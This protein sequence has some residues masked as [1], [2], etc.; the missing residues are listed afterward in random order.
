MDKLKM[1]GVFLLLIALFGCS[2]KD[3]SDKYSDVLA[4]VGND[5]IR[6]AELI[7][8]LDKQNR[9]KVDVQDDKVRQ[10]LLN[11]LVQSRLI[12]FYGLENKLNELNEVKIDVTTRRDEIYYEKVLKNHVYYP[13]ISESDLAA[14]YEKLKVEIRVRQILIGFLKPGKVFIKDVTEARRSKV[15]AK[16]LVD[17][18]YAILKAAPQKF[19]TLVEKYSDDYASKFLKGDAGFLRWGTKPVLEKAVFALNVGDISEPIETDNGFYLIKPVE[20]RT[21]A[22]SAHLM[23][24]NQ[25]CVK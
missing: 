25:V 24:Q 6:T 15:E 19:D 12:Y 14:F 13:L 16:L 11:N 8:L 2:K 3:E 20:K 7:K 1:A 4:V 10:D 21:S 17:S 23:K 22:I 5:T 18:L 9:N